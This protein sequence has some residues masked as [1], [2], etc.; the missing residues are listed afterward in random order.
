MW[1]A[2]TRRS[3]SRSCFLCDDSCTR[4][5]MSAR[6]TR[7][8]GALAF[9]ASTTIAVACASDAVGVDLCRQIEFA[10]CDRAE[11]CGV[12]LTTPAYVGADAA[13][14]CKRYYQDACRRGITSGKDPG[15]LTGQACVDA[16]KTGDCSVVKAPETSAACAF[17]IVT[18][19]VDAAP[20]STPGVDASADA[21]GDTATDANGIK[22]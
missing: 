17:L 4:G 8:G 7:R 11:A 10:R 1:N 3:L 5:R 15:G 18:P 14:A 9:V 19:V 12:P 16:I 6:L 20:D 2:Q 21:G 22:P 13:Q